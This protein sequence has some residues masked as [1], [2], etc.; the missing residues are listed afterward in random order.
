MEH[1]EEVGVAG[2]GGLDE[3]ARAAVHATDVLYAGARLGNG[4]GGAVGDDGGG[5]GGVEGLEGW[6]GEGGGGIA[7]VGVERV[8]DGELL[9]EKDDALGLGALEVVDF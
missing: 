3:E 6:R 2:G 7:R 8:G 4:D 9:A 5:A 1:L